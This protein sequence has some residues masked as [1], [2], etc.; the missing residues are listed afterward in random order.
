MSARSRDT[1]PSSTRD[2]DTRITGAVD[3]GS[4]LFPKSNEI[5]VLCQIIFRFHFIICPFWIPNA[6][7]ASSLLVRHRRPPAPRVLGR[8][9]RRQAGLD[10]RRPAVGGPPR[11]QGA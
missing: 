7:V 2:G 3:I 10:Q 9:G 6:V 5:I 8:R 1:S 11:D 4:Q